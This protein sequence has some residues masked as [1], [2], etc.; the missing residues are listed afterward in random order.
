MGPATP[1]PYITMSKYRYLRT[2]TNTKGRGKVKIYCTHMPHAGY[3]P[4]S[5]TIVTRQVKLMGDSVACQ[6]G[7]RQ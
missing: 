3:M 4:A 6:V 5:N 7:V 2:V 1:R